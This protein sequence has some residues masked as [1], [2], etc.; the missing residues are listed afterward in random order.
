[1][2]A[3]DEKGLSVILIYTGLL[4]ALIGWASRNKMDFH[5]RAEISNTSFTVAAILAGL[6]VVLFL[7]SLRKR[8]G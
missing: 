1:M 3:D 2:K 5:H 6:S 7:L 4:F 8:R